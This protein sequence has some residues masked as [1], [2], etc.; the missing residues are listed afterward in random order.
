MSVTSAE[1]S[2]PRPWQRRLV[3][4]LALAAVAHSVVI[5]FWLSPQSPVRSLF[6]SKNLTTYVNPYFEQSWSEL[7]P[8]AQFVDESFS[9][10]AQVKDDETGKITM[11]EWV[12]V[13]AVEDDSLRHDVDPARAHLMARKLATNLNGAMY[14]L[15]AKQRALVRESYTREPIAQ[16]GPRLLGAGNDRLG[17]VETY[18]AYDV[19]ATRFA[20]MYAK[21]RF[22]GRIL[23]VQYLVGRR[24]VPPAADRGTTTV[25]DKDFN[26]FRFGFRRGYDASFEAQTA[27]DDYVGK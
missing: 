15:N 9:L 1:P 11:S 5:A 3:V 21:A 8:N 26:Y 10:R 25:R 13:T 22:D 14:G 6:G 19:M 27:F 2:A 18:V 7:A 24:T 16:L 17:A 20:S 12:D 4:L 23:K